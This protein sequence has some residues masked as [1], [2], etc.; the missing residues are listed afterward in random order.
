[1]AM[2]VPSIVP[3]TFG[4]GCDYPSLLF[5]FLLFYLEIYC[6]MSDMNVCKTF[7]YCIW[8]IVHWEIPDLS[9]ISCWNVPM[10]KN[11][12]AERTWM[13]TG[14]LLLP[15]QKW[16]KLLEEIS[17]SNET[18]WWAHHSQ[19]RR[20][21]GYL[22]KNVPYAKL[23][24]SSLQARQSEPLSASLQS[25]FRWAFYMCLYILCQLWWL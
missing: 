3:I 23:Y 18:D 11:P 20:S 8:L 17:S 12:Q 21:C 1:M 25:V 19:K 24:V 14:M 4:K 9:P 15:L 16:G 5:S 2:C 22:K 7:V 13:C 6:G 10:A